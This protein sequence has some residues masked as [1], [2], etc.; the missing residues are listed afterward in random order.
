[1][2]LE[3]ALAVFQV[4]GGIQA[5]RE[6]NKQA[7]NVRAEAARQSRLAREEAE[8]QARAEARENIELEKRQKLSFLKSGVALEGSPLLLMS[9]TRREGQ[10][11]VGNILESGRTRQESIL[12]SGQ[13]QSDQLRSSGRQA[14]IGGLTGA[15]STASGGG[16]GSFGFG[17]NTGAGGNIPAPAIPPR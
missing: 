6:S 16:F 14:F 10:E 9:E 17:S 15:G 7:A 8:R 3:A 11:N 5:Q 12:R 1:M 2:G 13:L 4:V